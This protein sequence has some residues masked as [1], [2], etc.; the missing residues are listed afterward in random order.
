MLLSYFIGQKKYP[1]PYDLKAIFSYVLL[2]AAL[3]GVAYLVEL[4]N[5]WLRLAFRSLLLLLFLGWM[6]RKERFIFKR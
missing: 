5:L 4:D 1:I 3:F 6:I 2:A